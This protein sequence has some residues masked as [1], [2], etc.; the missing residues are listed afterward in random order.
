MN[1]LKQTEEIL[2]NDPEM[3]QK[4]AEET[5]RLADEGEKT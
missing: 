2:K 1:N 5:R 3:Q 4:L